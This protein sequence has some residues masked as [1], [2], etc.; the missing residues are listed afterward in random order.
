MM[1]RIELLCES[2]TLVGAGE[3]MAALVQTDV[4]YDEWGLP[5]FPARSI[6]GCLRE[7]ARE[8][9]GW[10]GD[11]FNQRIVKAVFGSAGGQRG[12]LHFYDFQLHDAQSM[13]PWLEWLKEQD[14]FFTTAKIISLYTDIRTQTALEN[15][16]AKDDTLRSFRVLCS[17]QR[18]S[19]PIE[20]TGWQ[21][22]E[23]ELLCLACYNLR[24]I[25]AK[26]TRGLGHV[27]CKVYDEQGCDLTAKTLE[28]VERVYINE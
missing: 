12:K 18:F 23:V 1:A 25:G 11:R 17:G 26:Q 24:Q 6:K 8:I 27:V 5:R 7:S 15:G 4:Y 22:E 14:D 3:G 28:R 2:D 9:C 16:I 19:A 13:K 20:L 10:L 21:P